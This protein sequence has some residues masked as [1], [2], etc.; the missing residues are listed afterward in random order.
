MQRISGDCCLISSGYLP[1]GCRAGCRGSDP[2]ED[3]ETRAPW[4]P[5]ASNA[6]SVQSLQVACVQGG[7]VPQ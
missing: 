4:R 3:Q 2:D 7:L 5:D 1:Q 6:C